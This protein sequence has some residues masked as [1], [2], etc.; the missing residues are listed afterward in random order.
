[1]QPENE[2]LLNKVTELI[3]E[4]TLKKLEGNASKALSQLFIYDKS[5]IQSFPNNVKSS[6]FENMIFLMPILRLLDYKI[7]DDLKR[8]LLIQIQR[9]CSNWNGQLMVE[10]LLLIDKNQVFFM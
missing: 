3:V 7:S 9:D 4:S 2:S 1:M 6:Y 10:S 5:V 8:I